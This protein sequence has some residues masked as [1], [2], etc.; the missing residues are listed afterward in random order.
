MSLNNRNTSNEI[1]NQNLIEQQ[2]NLNNKMK[3]EKEEEEEEEEE[4]ILLNNNKYKIKNVKELNNEWKYLNNNRRGG[5]LKPCKDYALSFII[6][7]KLLQIRKSGNELQITDN[8][9]FPLLD[10]WQRSNCFRSNSWIFESLG[11]TVLTFYDLERKISF[12]S[13]PKLLGGDREGNGGNGYI[14]RVDNSNGECFAH[15]FVG[16]PF[17]IQDKK[18][19]NIAKFELEQQQRNNN[20]LRTF[21]C[22]SENEGQLL[23]SLEELKIPT[24]QQ[25]QQQQLINNNNCL[26]MILLAAAA[27]LVAFCSPIKKIK[28]EKRN[29]NIIINEQQQQ[30]LLIIY[31]KRKNKIKCQ[32]FP[33]L[34]TII[35]I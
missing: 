25:Q 10:L 24:R 27:R 1:F 4:N 14:Q 6:D 11:L 33:K 22:I 35:I 21:H 16:I 26:F 34:T 8:E 20:Y 13:L 12:P 3:K 32:K 5:E 30:Q 9:G 15:F 28:E 18:R 31:W 17:L 23:A 29:E 19:I 2:K 7:A